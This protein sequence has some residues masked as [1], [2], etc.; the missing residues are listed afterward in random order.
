MGLIR[1]RWPGGKRVEGNPSY[2]LI[3]IAQLRLFYTSLYTYSLRFTLTLWSALINWCEKQALYTLSPPF[4]QPQ[5]LLLFVYVTYLLGLSIENFLS[6]WIV[7]SSSCPSYLVL[8]S[9]YPLVVIFSFPLASFLESALR[10]CSS[11]SSG[12]YTRSL[13]FPYHIS[14]PASPLLSLSI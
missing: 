3:Q 6:T 7:L 11:T 10:L 2:W 13:L 12:P 9:S 4:I 1:R 14:C 8:S 5:S